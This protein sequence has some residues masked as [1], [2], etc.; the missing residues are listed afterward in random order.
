LDL[1]LYERAGEFLGD[2]IA[3]NALKQDAHR[4]A[5]SA[6]SIRPPCG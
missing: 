2:E 4:L 5:A 3:M 6:A 1:A